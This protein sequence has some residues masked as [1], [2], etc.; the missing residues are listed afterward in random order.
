MHIYN[1]VILLKIDVDTYRGMKKGVPVLL[2]VLRRHDIKASFFLSFGPDNS[3]KAIWNIFRTKGFLS[4]MVRTG[5][6]RLYGFKTMLYGTLLPAP[7]ISSALPD[8]TRQIAEE[9][10]E[11]GVHAWD[12]RLW[13]DNL[14]KLSERR[15][16]EEFEKSFRSFKN[17]LGIT[18]KATAAPAWSCNLLSLKIQDSLGL[19]Y[20][21]DTRG[22]L[23]FY[24]R[25]NGQ[26]FKT[27]QIPTNQ[28]CIEEL[29]GLGFVNNDNLVKYQVSLLKQYLPNVV[30]IHAEVEGGIYKEE[31]DQFIRKTL[32]EGYRFY[33]LNAIAPG[34][35][36]APEKSVNYGHLPGRSGTVAISS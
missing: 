21:S 6:P 12:H 25:F 24:P 13:Q 23:P 34:F 8:L 27:L 30:T 36:D 3:G 1:R 4:K 20:S 7:L 26:L 35:H 29:I 2:E 19:D 22:R 32:T 9:G 33:P 15:I 17:I 18:P 31:F 11:I 14:D 28:P 10:H 16:R 5:A